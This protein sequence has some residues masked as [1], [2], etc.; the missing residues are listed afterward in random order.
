MARIQTRLLELSPLNVYFPCQTDEDIFDHATPRYNFERHT[1]I[2]LQPLY[3]SEESDWTEKGADLI[4]DNLSS[5]EFGLRLLIGPTMIDPDKLYHADRYHIRSGQIKRN[6]HIHMANDKVSTWKNIYWMFEPYRPVPAL[7]HVSRE[8]RQRA[9]RRCHALQHGLLQKEHFYVDSA[10][11]TL[12]LPFEYGFLLKALSQDYGDQLSAIRS[13]NVRLDACEFQRLPELQI[14][15]LFPR[16]L[17]LTLEADISGCPLLWDGSKP[18]S[19]ARKLFGDAE[20][21]LRTQ[22]WRVQISDCTDIVYLRFNGDEASKSDRNQGIK[23]LGEEENVEDVG[24][25]YEFYWW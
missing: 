25:D 18:I 12:G 22:N 9:L 11:D 15:H 20:S 1:K 19:L 13:L 3:F 7:L 24:D 23:D 21:Y 14:P 8:S 17:N 2:W 5:L 16:L 4:G 6:R 10:T